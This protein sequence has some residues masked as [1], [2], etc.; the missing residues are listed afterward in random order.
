[1]TS[2]EITR[3]PDEDDVTPVELFFDLVYV[4]AIGQLSH[5]LLQHPSW[6]GAAE[7]AVLFVAVFGSWSYTTWTTSLLHPDRAPVRWMLLAVMVLGLFM[8]AAIGEAFGEAGWLFVAT[9]LVSQLGRTAWALRAGLEHVMRDHFRRV[10]VWVVATS[11]LW[12]AGAAASHGPRL[13]LWATAAVLDLVGTVTA[14]PLPGRR[15]ESRG[16]TFAGSHLLERCRLFFL[17]AL[18]ETVVTTGTAVVQAPLGL[19]TLVTGTVAL[20]GTVA[21]WWLYFRRAE[22]AALRGLDESDDPAR[23][24]RYAIYSLMGMVA[25]LIAIAVGDQ[26]VIADPGG[27]TDVATVLMLCG[28]PALFLLAQGW[29]MHAAV[30]HLPRSRPVGV[31]ALVVAG[32][33]GLFLA[34]ALAALVAVAVLIAIAVTDGRRAGTEERSARA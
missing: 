1:M 20:V 9:Y 6:S 28:G 22:N 34:P 16:A 11:P 19:T 12:V 7:T 8:N 27:R 23:T 10:L 14:H 15:L 21:V 3:D 33:L 24:G 25:G 13:A 30:G 29:Y 17:I 26:R 32:A 31:A 5:H 2:R 18:G 4:F